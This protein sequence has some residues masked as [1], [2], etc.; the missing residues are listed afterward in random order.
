MSNYLKEIKKIKK[1]YNL[2]D[3]S[4]S[5]N[6]IDDEYTAMISKIDEN[7]L[8]KLINKYPDHEYKE[9]KK[10]I[11]LSFGVSKVILGSGS[12][13]LI[14]RI[15]MI[16]K[17]I[18]KIGIVVPNF[19]RIIETAGN[20]V[21]IP[22]EYDINSKIIDLS[23]VLQKI[24]NNIKSIWITNPNPLIG[25]ICIRKQLME[26]IKSRPNIIFVIDESSMGF[27]EEEQ[28]Y[29]LIDLAQKIDNLIVIRSFSKLYGVAGLRVGFATGKVG[30]IDKVER[31]GPTFPINGLAEYFTRSIL[32]NKS[33]V[34]NIR[35]KIIENKEKVEKIL[36]DNDNI[37]LSKSATNCIFFKHVGKSIFDKMLDMGIVVLDLNHQEGV[38]EKD[39]VRLTIHSSKPLFNSI[40]SCIKKVI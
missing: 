3:Y 33:V 8:V 7:K 21:K 22:V 18:G 37:I 2:Q 40:M 6:N 10:A 1:K 36:T 19:Y 25:K 29:S 5:N 34:R 20:C 13:D 16:L 38:R 24:S 27:V 15:N 9:L 32:K 26:I 4:L 14:I 35:D 28:K 31:I 11:K 23:G 39:F 17:D 30:I 12:E